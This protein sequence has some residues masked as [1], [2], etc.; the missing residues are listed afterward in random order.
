MKNVFY[1]ISRCFLTKL[2]WFCQKK[3]QKLWFIF[4][5]SNIRVTRKFFIDENTK[6]GFSDMKK[7][8]ITQEIYK[9]TRLVTH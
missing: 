4:K 5:H 9:V 2:C 3:T 6:T 1:I 8:Q 7:I